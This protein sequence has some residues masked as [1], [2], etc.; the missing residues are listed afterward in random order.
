M[1]VGLAPQPALSPPCFWHCHLQLMLEN[2]ELQ[3]VLLQAGPP[4]PWQP[5]ADP[6]P[7][8]HALPSCFVSTFPLGVARY[9]QLFQCNSTFSSLLSHAS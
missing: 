1:L 9:W 5:A 6:P 2:V 7:Q 3:R 8:Q 4:L